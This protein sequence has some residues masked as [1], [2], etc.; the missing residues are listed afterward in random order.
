MYN[1]DFAKV[2]SKRG[3]GQ[4]CENERPLVWRKLNRQKKGIFEMSVLAERQLW[5]EK[6][7]R[8]CGQ[9]KQKWTASQK[10]QLSLVWCPPLETFTAETHWCAVWFCRFYRRKT[11]D[12]LK[13]LPDPKESS[14]GKLHG[15][16]TLRRYSLTQASHAERLWR[17]QWTC[18][19]TFIPY[20]AM[21]WFYAPY[22][23]W[24]YGSI[25]E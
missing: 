23:T 20:E 13:T 5:S 1:H 16:K 18:N 15:K 12:H 17:E 11:K 22:I 14:K 9:G 21:P 7:Q 6:E 8:P 10:G 19:I 4:F 2:Q 3:G 25:A 24:Q